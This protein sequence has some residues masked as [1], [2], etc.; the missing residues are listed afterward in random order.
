[1]S[2]S[3]MNTFGHKLFPEFRII[4]PGRIPRNAIVRSER[5]IHSETADTDRRHALEKGR[6]YTRARAHRPRKGLR[7]NTLSRRRCLFS[8][9]LCVLVVR[10]VS[11]LPPHL[12]ESLANGLLSSCRWQR[13]SACCS[14]YMFYSKTISGIESL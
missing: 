7:L 9:T 2:N 5:K 13:A 10:N 6:V 14:L 12:S 1:M 11:F 8:Q 3:A 4:S